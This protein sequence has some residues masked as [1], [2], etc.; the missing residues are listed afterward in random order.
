MISAW[1]VYWVMQL[2]SIISITGWLSFFGCFFGGIGFIV[3]RVARS[4]DDEESKAVAAATWLSKPVLM[5]GL[6]SLF[7]NGFLPSS[8][9]AAAMIVLPAITSDM[10]I[11]TVSPEARELYGLAKGALKNLGAKDKAAEPEKAK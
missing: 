9:T 2:D 11:D 1:Q 8:K 5:L 3:H 6:L 10:V 4:M 7:A